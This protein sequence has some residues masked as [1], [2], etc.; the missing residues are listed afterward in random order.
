MLQAGWS[1]AAVEVPEVDLALT[2]PGAAATVHDDLLNSYQRAPTHPRPPAGLR[3]TAATL[4]AALWVLLPPRGAA[5]GLP[6]YASGGI[7][8]GELLHVEAGAYLPGGLSLDLTGGWLIFNPLVGVGVTKAFGHAERA[9]PSRHA[10]LL[11]GKLRINPALGEL[12]LTGDG[13]E[14][15]GATAEA[16]GGYGFQADG[17]FLFRVFGGAVVYPVSGGGVEAGPNV[18]LSLGASFGG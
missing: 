9:R 1:H 10:F 15:V 7:G 2:V 6:G 5:A 11:N 12:R 17:G 3:L 14:T 13:G 8:L 4:L 16:Y 18:Y